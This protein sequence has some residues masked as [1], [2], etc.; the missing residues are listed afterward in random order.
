MKNKNKGFTLIELMVVIS[1]IGVLSSVVLAGL[2]STRVKAR[3]SRIVQGVQQLRN[4]IEL[5]RSGDSYPS[6]FGS[7]AS[8]PGAPT[9]VRLARDAIFTLTYPGL[10]H[11]VTDILNQNN[12]LYPAGYGGTSVAYFACTRQYDLLSTTNA[13]TIYIDNTTC[14]A[15][16]KYAIYAAMGPVIGSSG[17]FCID[18]VGKTT[19]TTSGAIPVPSTVATCQ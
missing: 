10:T 16:T 7:A 13:L 19:K 4:Q 11:L 15:A 17:Y 5:T 12:L 18:S 14:G 1:I 3:N 6:L 9:T 8:G 2:Q